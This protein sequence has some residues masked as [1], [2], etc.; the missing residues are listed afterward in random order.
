MIA[1]SAPN[2]V[3]ETNLEKFSALKGSVAS[4]VENI[5]DN[6]TVVSLQQEPEEEEVSVAVS[7][8]AEPKEVFNDF[9]SLEKSNVISEMPNA[10]SLFKAII[11]KPDDVNENS[12]L[13]NIL[14]S[15]ENVFKAK[16]SIRTV[17][18]EPELFP[19]HNPSVIVPKNRKKSKN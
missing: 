8:E 9:D 6:A 1:P 19:N 15:N 5:I 18:E 10:S 7:V 2:E 17:E 13:E 3:I 16:S 11:N 4:E 14:S 12:Q